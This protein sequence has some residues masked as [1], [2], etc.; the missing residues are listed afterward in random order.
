MIALSL[1]L[2]CLLH[3]KS[4]LRNLGR[5]TDRAKIIM[6][7]ER[8]VAIRV[9]RGLSKKEKW[10]L[11]QG[12]INPQSVTTSTMGSSWGGGPS[13]VFLSIDADGCHRGASKEAEEARAPPGKSTSSMLLIHQVQTIHKNSRFLTITYMV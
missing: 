5:H 7:Q 8:K 4:I 10:A 2:S 9:K 6:Q 1:R 11:F 12:G 13:M 3:V